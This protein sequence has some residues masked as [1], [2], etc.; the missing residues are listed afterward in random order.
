MSTFVPEFIR[1]MVYTHYSHLHIQSVNL[2]TNKRAQQVKDLGAKTGNS[3]SVPKTDTLGENQL[4]QGVPDFYKYIVVCPHTP[5]TQQMSKS[6]E[7][8]RL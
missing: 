3:S 5:N 8:E 4:S 1:N 7:K 6:K 2:W